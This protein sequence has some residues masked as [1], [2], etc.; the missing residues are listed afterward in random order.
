M[1]IYHT[2]VKTFSRSQGH[3]STAAAAYRAG[4]L[5]VDARTGLKHDYRRRGGVVETRCIA[6][7]EAPDWAFD[8]CELWPAAEASE[9]RK[10]ATV[11][12]EFE[13]ALPHELTDDER[14]ALTADIARAL[15][16]RYRFAIQASIH[17]PQTPDGLNYHAH[18]LATT[19]RVGDAGLADKT[20]ELDGGPSGR[21]EVEWIRE[22]VAK[23]IN[24]HL[25]AAQIQARVDHRS[26]EAQAAEAADLGDEATAL[27]LSREPTEHIGKDATALHRRGVES[28]RVQANEAITADNEAQW[29]EALA[30]L[31]GEGR[32]QPVSA[33]HS[34][35]QARRERGVK[36]G[37]VL[38]L[39]PVHGQGQIRVVRGL[40]RGALTPSGSRR[41]ERERQGASRNLLAEAIQLWKEDFM[42]KVGVTF[43]ATSQ[44]LQHGAERLSAFA[45]VPKFRS[46]LGELVK[47]LKR[48]RHDA[49][50]FTRR[51]A[52]EERAQHLLSQAERALEQFEADHPKPGLWSRAEWSKRRARRLRTVQTR[53]DAH[54]RA[55]HATGPEAQEGYNV[56]A[57]ASAEQLEAWSQSMLIRYPVPA[58]TMPAGKAAS[59]E[60]AVSTED[61]P[62]VSTSGVPA[63]PA[64][65]ESSS[66]LRPK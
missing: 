61:Q 36:P 29:K 28:E 19:R 43:K 64:S 23:T 9:K 7:D 3:A 39:S 48:L 66:S 57:K 62:E 30:Q 16:E 34:Q 1:A 51:R 50:R 49:E 55:R 37:V 53:R 5:I 65:V 56:Q 42:A 21:G 2:R 35:E 58:D 13:I 59:A 46:D 27:A 15:V 24:S 4:L 32:L 31:E 11:A 6:P 63:K 22:M 12:R 38:D 52:A 47:R 17:E 25:A 8:P 45:H 26:L 14:S 54:R 44:L 18:L 33:G 60:P 10:D 40:S 20:R 41:S